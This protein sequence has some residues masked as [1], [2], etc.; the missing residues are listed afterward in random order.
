M[1]TRVSPKYPVND[2]GLTRNQYP[3]YACKTNKKVKA[4]LNGTDVV[5]VEQWTKYRVLL[6]PRSRSCG[7]LW[8]IVYEMW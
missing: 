7:T 3:Y 2:C 5:N 8:F 4:L 1:K 6:L